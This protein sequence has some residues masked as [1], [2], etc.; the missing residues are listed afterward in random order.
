M[1]VSLRKRNQLTIPAAIVKSTNIYTNDILEID[2]KNGIITLKP[3]PG[4]KRM[5]SSF[6]TYA[7][8]DRGVWGI[9]TDEIEQKIANRFD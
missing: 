8:I 6:M 7:G 9:T 5:E 4:N 3:K 1:Q 2:Y